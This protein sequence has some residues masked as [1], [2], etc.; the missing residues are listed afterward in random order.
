MTCRCRDGWAR[1][2]TSIAPCWR[3]T[4]KTRPAL[5]LLGVLVMQAGQV[6]SGLDLV[7]QSLEILPGFAPAQENLGKGLEQLGRMEEA[8]AAYGRLVQLAPD[9]AEPYAHRGRVLQHLLAPQRGAEGFRQGAVA[10]K[11]SGD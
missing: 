6:E 11:R 3:K 5:H 7:R 8:L 1:P 10:E 9:Y 4:R 2:P